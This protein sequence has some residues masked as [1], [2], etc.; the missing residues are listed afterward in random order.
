MDAGAIGGY[1]LVS[2]V[3]IFVEGGGET[4]FLKRRC[5]EG[6]HD[7]LTKAGFTGR[8]PRIVPCGSR[9]NAFDDFQTAHNQS[10][11]AYVA[12]LVDS[13]DPIADIEQTWQHLTMRDGWTRPD[14]AAEDQVFLMT[15]C[16][17]TWIIAD[18]VALSQH[19]RSCLQVSA[20][21][22]VHNLEQRDRHDVQNRLVNAT[23]T[24][25]NAYAKN[26]RSFE[27]LA[28]INPETIKEMLP[29]FARMVHILD[30][31]L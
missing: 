5:S 15:T 22:P 10:K 19:Y 23:H 16:M 27:A 30:A 20:L 28:S 24:C 31:K 26:K 14:G 9:N 17:E 29:S 2:K 8:L 25:T 13:E 11:Q 12:L 6:F 4:S 18:R 21:P 1:A 3:T 7:L